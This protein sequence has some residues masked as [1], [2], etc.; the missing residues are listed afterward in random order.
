[1]LN[2][3]IYNVSEIYNYN[4]TEEELSAIQLLIEKK[5]KT[6]EWNYGYGPPYTFT[7][8]IQIDEKSHSCRLVVKDGI[9]WE[10]DIEGSEE[11]KAAGKK[12]IG[13]RHMYHDLLK[14][15]RTENIPVK[16]DDVYKF[17]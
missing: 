1:M 9:I 16:E 4:I 13:C 3:F 17:F 8:R 6:W 14:K 5:Y 10:C 11:M 7:N 15:F 2:Y 12:L